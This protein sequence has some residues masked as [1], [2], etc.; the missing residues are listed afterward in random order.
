ME[1]PVLTVAAYA[2]TL[3]CLAAYIYMTQHDNPVPFYWANITAGLVLSIYNISHHAYANLLLN[4]TFGLF[5]A[6]GLR[7]KRKAALPREPLTA[8]VDDG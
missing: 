2:S 3:G 8:G 5:A 7:R 4:I 6:W 1:F